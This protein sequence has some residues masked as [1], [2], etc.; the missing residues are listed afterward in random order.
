MSAQISNVISFPPVRDGTGDGPVPAKTLLE[1]CR[2][3]AVE[4][5]GTAL[6]AGFDKVIDELYE[7]AEHALE[8]D[9]R[10]F[11]LK[12]KES[13]PQQRAP[14]ETTFRSQL[15]GRFSPPI[16]QDKDEEPQFALVKSAWTE[17]ALVADGDLEE[18]MRFTELASK[19]R[20]GADE[21]LVGLDQRMAI[22]LERPDLESADNPLA[23]SGIA[24]AFREAL[25]QVEFDL[26]IKRIA[27][28]HANA[29]AL[30]SNTAS[31]SGVSGTGS[32]RPAATASPI[33]PVSSTSA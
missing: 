20:N 19:I 18:D 7:L 30:A 28:R 22:V 14:V 32:A 17:L 33:P 25:K 24:E 1:E 31:R 13:W 8:R 6:G 29:A 4:R 26:E 3:L 10:D 27:I 9:K 11:Y 5:L 15:S 23:P 21:E 16:R 2:G 12:A